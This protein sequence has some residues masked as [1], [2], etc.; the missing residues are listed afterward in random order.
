MLLPVMHYIQN[1]I[2]KSNLIFFDMEA[3]SEEINQINVK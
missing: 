3:Q 1:S 2:L